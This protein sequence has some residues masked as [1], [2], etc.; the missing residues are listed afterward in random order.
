MGQWPVPTG[1]AVRLSVFD[2]LVL[3][4]SLG[5]AD[6][7]VLTGRLVRP[8]LTLPGPGLGGGAAEQSPSRGAGR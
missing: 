5:A 4:V 8:R 2:Q 1:C 3:Q 6:P 7:V